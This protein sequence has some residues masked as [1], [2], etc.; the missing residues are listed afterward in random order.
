MNSYIRDEFKV[1]LDNI[2]DENMRNYIDKR[3][4]GQIEWYDNSSIKNQKKYRSLIVI[5]TIMSGIIPVL[6]LFLDLECG[7]MFKVIISILSACAA[8]ISSI[9]AVFN[10]RELWINYRVNCEV[11]KS[12]LHLFF[13][14]PDEKSY[15][16]LIED[17]ESCMTS[18]FRS[19]EKLKT[20]EIPS[21]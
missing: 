6:T 17:C 5:S 12:K 21:K 4:I 13:N 20:D 18:E 14:S 3:V 16:K 10:Y 19:W 2:Q 8:I 1:Y 15:L 11:L 9:S 7:F